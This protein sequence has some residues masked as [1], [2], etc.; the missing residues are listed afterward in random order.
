MTVATCKHQHINSDAK[1]KGRRIVISPSVVKLKWGTSC[2]RSRAQAIRATGGQRC[3]SDEATTSTWEKLPKS[4]H[5][6]LRTRLSTGEGE[7]L[8]C[9][10]NSTDSKDRHDRQLRVRLVHT[11]WRNFPAQSTY[12]MFEQ[13]AVSS[14]SKIIHNMRRVKGRYNAPPFRI[15]EALCTSKPQQCDRHM[16]STLTRSAFCDLHDAGQRRLKDNVEAE[17][18][19]ENLPIPCPIV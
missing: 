7:L 11:R 18:V 8:L 17:V 12:A 10:S 4:R 14:C 1:P 3:H 9:T 19:V 2:V 13:I 15:Q 6:T 16:L 5:P